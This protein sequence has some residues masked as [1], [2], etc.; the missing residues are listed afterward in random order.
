MNVATLGSIVMTL[1]VTGGVTPAEPTEYLSKSLPIEDRVADLLGRMTLEEKVGQMVQ[2]SLTSLVIQEGCVSEESLDR[3]FGGQSCGT[4]ETRP[5]APPEE[6][7][8]CVQAAQDY[9]RKRTRLGIPAVPIAECLHG[10][11]SL[12]ATIFPQANAQGATWN[13]ELVRQMAAATATEA[14]AMGVV[15]CLSP[16]FDLARDPRY[17]RVE[18]CYGE[19]PTLVARMGTAFVEGAQGASFWRSG[20]G[21]N[22]IICTA[23]HFAGY[24]VP[25]A[26]LNCAPAPLGEREMRSLFLVPFEAAVK[27]AGIGS[28]MPSYNEVD[29]VPSHANRWLLTTVLRGEWG[30]QGYVFSDYGAIYMLDDWHHVAAN[31]PDAGIVALR[32]GVDLEAPSGAAYPPLVEAVKSGNA[33]ETMIDEA[34][35]RILR[36]KFLAGLFDGARTPEPA[37]FKERIHTAEH[38]ALARRLAEESIILLKNEG[39]LLPLDPTKLKSVAVIGPNADQVQFGDYAPCKDNAYGVTVLAGLQNLLGKRVEL[40]HAGGCG[41]VGLAK[42]GFG[43]AVEATRK[44]DVAIVV[45]GDTSVVFNERPPGDLAWNRLGTVGEGYDTTDLT[46]PGVQEDLVRAVHAIGKPVI[47]VL[48]HGRAYSIGWMKENIPAIV[49]AWYPGEQGGHAIANVLF[50]LVNPSGRLNVSVPQ[51]AGHVPTVYDYKQTGRGCSNRRGT[52]EKPGMDYVFG[53][54]DPLFPFGFGL[55]YTTFEY[56]DLK[57]ET[58][59]VQ[60]NGVVRMS[61]V[62]QN[63]G[64]RAGSEVAQIYIRDL[65]SSTT[66]PVMRLRRFTKAALGPG[67]KRRLDFE[68][69]AAELAIWNQEMKQ[70]VEPGGFEIMVAASAED[71]RLRGSFEVQIVDSA[72]PATTKPAS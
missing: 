11:Q 33:P 53:S 55:T 59:S 9:L 43:A 25:Q 41:I 52:P 20:L 51:S 30:F 48:M 69:P 63:T 72:G 28:V 60:A 19:C 8:L 21:T 26:G 7:A 42:D 45:I 36:A 65:V 24:S 62:L 1:G 58:P 12:G 67:E 23:K 29:G 4:L 10:V 37:K 32:A 18:E 57:I 3:L 15:Q 54:P 5:G 14:S 64:A 47:V 39:N 50:G 38:V 46:P 16:L 71:V 31:V 27:E 22:Q 2:K 17:G 13:P 56:A 70:V 68:I 61:F 44:S 34:V 49:E 6:T 40:N 35:R 66:T